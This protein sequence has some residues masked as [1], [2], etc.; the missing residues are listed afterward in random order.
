M[1]KEKTLI[2]LLI[3]ANGFLEERE[4]K[5]DEMIFPCSPFYIEYIYLYPKLLEKISNIVS[6]EIS[7]FNPKI[8]F[9]IESAILPLATKVSDILQLPLSII[10]KPFYK[11]HEKEEPQIYINNDMNLYEKEKCIIF[12]DS[13]FSGK[14]ICHA[15]KLLKDKNFNNLQ[16]FFLIDVLDFIGEKIQVDKQYEEIINNRTCLIKYTNLIEFAYKIGHISKEA[17]MKTLLL[18]PCLNKSID[19]E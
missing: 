2:K 19:E 1:D 3:S 5:I 11:G 9:A 4:T 12:D 10:R 18:C 8:I 7:F 17:W 15:I 16:L 13:I 6:K 14:Q